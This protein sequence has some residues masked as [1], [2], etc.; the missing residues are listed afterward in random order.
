MLD[1]SS[2]T[3][4]SI[5]QEVHFEVGSNTE[6]KTIERLKFAASQQH[7]ELKLCENS[8]NMIAAAS[9]LSEDM[10]QTQKLNPPVRK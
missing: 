6:S 3:T 7:G 9:N 10:L 4:A 8:T 1:V 2:T 5:P